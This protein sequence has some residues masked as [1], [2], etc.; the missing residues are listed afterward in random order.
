M[1]YGNSYTIR[2]LL[3]AGVH[4]GHKRNYW[5]PKM[6]RY[7]YGVK[8]GI[9]VVDLEQT[10][11][12]LECALE[13]VQDVV[14]RDGRVLFLST[15]KQAREIVA[16]S[17][18]RCGQYYVNHRWLGGTFTNWRTVSSSIGTLRKYEAMLAD[19]KSLLTK[20]EKLNV[21]RK[22]E[23]LE[24]VLGGIRNMGGIPDLLFVI[25]LRENFT[26]VREAK[27]M[28]IRVIGIADT[29]CDPCGIDYVIPGND[30]AREALR[31]YCNLM[32]EAVL[33][34]MRKNV[35]SASD[36]IGA[37]VELRSSM[38]GVD[39]MADRG[40][41]SGTACGVG[42]SG[43]GDSTVV[44]ANEAAKMGEISGAAV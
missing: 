30:D 21:Q 10:V 15:K 39:E 6:A 29:N 27:K 14:S 24:L 16:D 17:A 40:E 35:Y 36:D 9:H 3:E 33:N 42:G 19:E 18:V 1:F 23:K 38:V 8:N 41:E 31:L 4:Y 43:G 5:N 2:S 32:S 13:A 25:G 20:K 26:A 37:S 11:Q 12:C 22:K 7:I 34:G 28:H 44:S